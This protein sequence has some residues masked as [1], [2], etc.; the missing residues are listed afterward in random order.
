MNPNEIFCG[1]SRAHPNLLR[2]T[3]STE[4]T[5]ETTPFGTKGVEREAPSKSRSMKVSVFYTG[6]CPAGSGTNSFPLCLSA[7]VREIFI[8]FRFY[9]RSPKIPYRLAIGSFA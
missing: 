5:E 8:I 6:L 9:A 3:E 7:F 2:T 4:S 1:G